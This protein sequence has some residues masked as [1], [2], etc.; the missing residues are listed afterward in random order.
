M[1][2]RKKRADEGAASSMTT[3]IESAALTVPL[4]SRVFDSKLEQ[5]LSALEDQGGLQAFLDSLDKKHRLFAQVLEKEAVPE[6]DREAVGSMVVTVFT[7][8]RR[9]PDAL[10][11]VPQETVNAA[12]STLIYGTDALAKRMQHFVDIVP[13]QEGEGRDITKSNLKL[14]RA[15][16]DFAAEMLHFRVPETYP[17][18]S[19]WV[20]D[21][22]T[23]SG[24]I[25][26]FVTSNDSL[27]ETPFDSRPETFEAVRQ[28]MAEQFG[29]SGF[30]RYVHFLIDLAQ[31]WAYTDYMRAMSSTMN[32]IEADFGGKQDPTEPV[33]KLLGIDPARRSGQSRL[34]R[35]T[36]H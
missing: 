24:A 29:T 6:L 5:L 14:Q 9:L 36:V 16:W 13:L 25:R 34:K 17:L 31:A 23:V 10:F 1:L 27:R 8:R 30:Y 22:D 33:Q 4:D 7:A 11:S 2:W 28:W 32:L 20:W 26:E 18:M 21:A 3:V 15:A 12:I 35:A 19:H